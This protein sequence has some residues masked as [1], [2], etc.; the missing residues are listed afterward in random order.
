MRDLNV[1]IRYKTDQRFML[2]F[3]PIY[4]ILVHVLHKNLPEPEPGHA[5]TIGHA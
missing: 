3:T 4:A 1:I 2:K 5:R